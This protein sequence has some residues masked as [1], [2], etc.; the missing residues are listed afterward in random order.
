[1]N[2]YWYCI[3]IEHLSFPEVIEFIHTLSQNVIRYYGVIPALIIDENS[4]DIFTGID[5]SFYFQERNISVTDPFPP[6][7]E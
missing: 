1:M 6:R 4:L 3:N 2:G 5:I 7:L